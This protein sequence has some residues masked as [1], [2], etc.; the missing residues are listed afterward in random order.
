MKV[1]GNPTGFVWKTL[2]KTYLFIWLCQVL[3]TVHGIFVASCGIFHCVIQTPKP[4]GSVV[5]VQ[6]LSYST[7]CGILVP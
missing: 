2:L 1:S 4:V 5:V 6:G 3:I 7:V